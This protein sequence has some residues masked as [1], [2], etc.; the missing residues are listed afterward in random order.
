[1]LMQRMP[2]LCIRRLAV[3]DALARECMCCLL[4]TA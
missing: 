1:M 3:A 2:V 4:L